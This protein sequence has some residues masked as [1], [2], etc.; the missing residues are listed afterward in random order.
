MNTNETIT[1]DNDDDASMIASPLTTC[2]NRSNNHN[3]SNSCHTLNNTV[4]LDVLREQETDFMEDEE[5]ENH[6]IATNNRSC[7]SKPDTKVILLTIVSWVSAY[8]YCNGVLHDVYGI[9]ELATLVILPFVLFFAC[10]IF[11]FRRISVVEN[12]YKRILEEQEMSEVVTAN[13]D[14]ILIEEK[15]I[16]PSATTSTI[17][18][19]EMEEGV[20]DQLSN[21]LLVEKDDISSKKKKKASEEKKGMIEKYI[22]PQF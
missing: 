17:L 5:E 2:Q 15:G 11:C 21:P 16:N 22:P 1:S 4:P 13:N 14:L 20:G 9:F 3:D 7:F 19:K 8:V 12:D 6:N 10:L 18:I